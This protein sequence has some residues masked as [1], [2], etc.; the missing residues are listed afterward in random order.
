MILYKATYTTV[1]QDTQEVQ[2]ETSHY[3]LKITLTFLIIRVPNN[4]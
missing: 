2:F 4:I 3:V 1:N